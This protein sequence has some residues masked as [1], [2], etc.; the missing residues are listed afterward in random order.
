MLDNNSSTSSN[1]TTQH[2]AATKTHTHN[3]EAII[4][5]PRER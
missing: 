5:I 1:T 2:T 3:G 4:P